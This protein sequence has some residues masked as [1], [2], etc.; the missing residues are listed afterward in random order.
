MSNEKGRDACFKITRTLDW[1][2]LCETERFEY[3][4][5]DDCKYAQGNDGAHDGM[6][7]D[8]ALDTLRCFPCAMVGAADGWAESLVRRLQRGGELV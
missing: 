4:R 1:P 2:Q 7:D 5:R 8:E 6:L 3:P